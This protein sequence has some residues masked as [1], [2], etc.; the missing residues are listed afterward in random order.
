MADI[1]PYWL[2]DAGT[3]GYSD[4]STG[5]NGLANYLSYADLKIG[6]SESN[7]TDLPI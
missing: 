5:K 7:D 3:T 6:A 1:L 2:I 4:I